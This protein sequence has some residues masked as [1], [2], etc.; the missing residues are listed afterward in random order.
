M[1]K[2]MLFILASV[3]FL[4]TGCIYQ[5]VDCTEIAK[6]L[7]FCESRGGVKRIQE[8]FIAATYIECWNGDEVQDGKIELTIPNK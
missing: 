1:K 8:H 5:N 4:L 6:A 3:F 7:Q 2:K